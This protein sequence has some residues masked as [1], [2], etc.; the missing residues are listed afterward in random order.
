MVPLETNL[1]KP[2]VWNIVVG[3]VC[4][5]GISSIGLSCPQC[6]HS[7]T[8]MTERCFL[9]VMFTCPQY[10]KSD[11]TLK[12]ISSYLRLLAPAS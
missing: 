1:V 4:V 10:Q 9:L 3:D 12:V 5:N 8:E 11:D 6:F 2:P 7:S